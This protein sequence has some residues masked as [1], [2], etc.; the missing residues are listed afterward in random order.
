MQGNKSVQQRLGIIF[1]KI[2][3]YEKGFV[4]D[5]NLMKRRIFSVTLKNSKYLD[6]IES[7]I[8]NFKR[9]C[10]K[11][12]KIINILNE[13]PLDKLLNKD[14]SNSNG[15]KTKRDSNSK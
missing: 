6:K 10:D 12:R 13:I 2:N 1:G 11:Q 7:H 4:K 5:A 8:V 9:C 15:S 14:G 3:H